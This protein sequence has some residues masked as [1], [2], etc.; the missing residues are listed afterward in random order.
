MPLEDKDKRLTQAHGST[1]RAFVAECEP[2][3]GVDGR[4]N[5]ASSGW[6]DIP[7]NRQSCQQR[8]VNSSQMGQSAFHVAKA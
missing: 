8:D 4:R 2:V 7:T 6:E 3:K 5:E 1:W